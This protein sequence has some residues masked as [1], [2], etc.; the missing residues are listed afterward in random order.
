MS[1]LFISWLNYTRSDGF[2]HSTIPP[3]TSAGIAAHYTEPFAAGIPTSGFW[4]NNEVSQ[5]GTPDIQMPSAAEELIDM[6]GVG[7]A[8]GPIMNRNLFV[9]AFLNG[10][11]WAWL[12]GARVLWCATEETKAEKR[13]NWTHLVSAQA[14]KSASLNVSITDHIYYLSLKCKEVR[15]ERNSISEALLNK[16]YMMI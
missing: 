5:T 7:T 12:T 9:G 14:R 15:G 6:T 8:K 11:H 2:Q 1:Q 4:K 16:N 10:N 13:R 3:S